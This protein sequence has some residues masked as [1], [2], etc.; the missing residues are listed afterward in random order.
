MTMRR[1]HTLTSAV[2]GPIRVAICSKRKGLTSEL[3]GEVLADDAFE[4][5]VAF[6]EAGIGA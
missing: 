3:A 4:V 5:T 1:E 6:A 2:E